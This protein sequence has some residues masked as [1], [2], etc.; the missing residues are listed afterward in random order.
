MTAAYRVVIADRGD[1][2][3]VTVVCPSCEA[4]LSLTIETANIPENCSSCGWVLR[5]NV[6]DALAALAR[7][8][9]DGKQ[10]ETEVGKGMF[11]FEIRD[12]ET[13]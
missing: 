1:I 3:K 9:R 4:A 2:A 7:F 10:A 13:D 11:R 12:R 8:H 6:R 5:K